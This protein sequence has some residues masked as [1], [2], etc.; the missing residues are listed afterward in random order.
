MVQPSHMG[1][2]MITD[3]GERFTE[4]CFMDYNHTTG[5]FEP[6]WNQTATVT[7]SQLYDDSPIFAAPESPHPRCPASSEFEYYNHATDPGEMM[8]L[9]AKPSPESQ[10]AMTRLRA[11]LHA[12][13]R[14][15][16]VP[17]P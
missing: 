11:Q 4:W 1:Y 10:A 15:A 9:A 5:A 8:N 7:A 2:T 16:L 12:G 14:T 13:W 17:Q 3:R 6:Q